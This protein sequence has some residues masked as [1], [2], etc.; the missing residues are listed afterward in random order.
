MHSFTQLR[1]RAEHTRVNRQLA[2]L[3]R[4]QRA[5][6]ATCKLYE[7]PLPTLYLPDVDI[8]LAAHPLHNRHRNALGVGDPTAVRSPSPSIQLNLAFEP[9]G[10]RPNARFLRARDGAYWVGHT[11]TLGGQVAGRSRE[12]FRA[13]VGTAQPV[14]IDD[15]EQTL[16]LLGSF[17]AP[18]PLLARI[19]ELV[20]AA[21]TYRSAAAAGATLEPCPATRQTVSRLP[22]AR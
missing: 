18:G 11:G 1:S 13:F 14:Q 12:G 10:A 16:I 19:V 17:S 15:R 4:A 21:H 5:R 22:L 8:W 2:A 9:G 7:G 3:F 20:H 6:R